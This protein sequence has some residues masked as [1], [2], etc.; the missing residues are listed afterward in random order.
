M[1]NRIL[2]AAA[3]LALLAAF[4]SCASGTSFLSTLAIPGAEAQ[5]TSDEQPSVVY[6][7]IKPQVRTM[8]VYADAVRVAVDNYENYGSHA[9]MAVYVGGRRA[10]TVSSEALRK[11]SGR[12]NISNDGKQYF[13]PSTGYE[14]ELVAEY[15]DGGSSEGVSVNA[16]TSQDS[17]WVIH[18]GTQLYAEADGDLTE[19]MTADG[20]LICR[21]VLTDEELD[22]LSGASRKN[23]AKYL[24]AELPIGDGVNELG[25]MQYS[26][27]TYY[28]SYEPNTTVNRKTQAAVRKVVTDYAIMMTKIPDQTYQLSGELVT[29]DR[30]VSDCSGLTE[31]AYLQIGYYLEHYAD[32]QANNYGKVI[33]DNLEPAGVSQGV[34]TYTLKDEESR[35]DIKELMKGDLLFFMEST[36]SASDNDLYV[37]NGIGHVAMYLGSGKMAHFTAAYGLTDHPCRIE[38]LAEYDE[39]LRVVK[40]VRYIV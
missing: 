2:T 34:E 11:S 15:D 31:L 28:V 7:H 16:A 25:E 38:D 35:V 20:E 39:H 22:P 1:N 36:N 24:R 14:I 33:Y 10:G 17:Y 21:G 18:Q 19:A 6:E 5:Q 12:I 8:A 23:E 32:R 40:A 26:Y 4:I 37:D 27:R 29:A 3:S 9:V 13:T 30:T